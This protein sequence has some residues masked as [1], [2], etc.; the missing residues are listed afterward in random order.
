MFG[1]ERRCVQ[2]MIPEQ[3]YVNSPWKAHLPRELPLE[4]VTDI[5]LPNELPSD[6]EDSGSMQEMEM[7]G[8]TAEKIKETLGPDIRLHTRKDKSG[9]KAAA[10]EICC[11]DRPVYNAGFMFNTSKTMTRW[12]NHPPTGLILPN[13]QAGPV[14]F[15]FK[16]SAGV[17]FNLVLAT[18]PVKV[19]EGVIDD[20]RTSS[21]AL[22]CFSCD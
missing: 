1:G 20:S 11:S 10:K 19:S 16:A 21:V 9:A 5:V 4:Y 3:S 7:M 17:S 15:S 14:F 22:S 8:W 12:K 6:G 18:D 13:P 2:V